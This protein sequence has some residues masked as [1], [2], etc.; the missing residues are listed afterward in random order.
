MQADYAD[1]IIN[2]LV[3]LKITWFLLNVLAAQMPIST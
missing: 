2:H 3:P 1:V